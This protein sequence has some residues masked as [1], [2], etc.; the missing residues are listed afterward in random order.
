MVGDGFVAFIDHLFQL[1]KKYEKNL[2]DINV[3]SIVGE[4]LQNNIFALYRKTLPE[5]GAE[6]VVMITKRHE[7]SVKMQCYDLLGLNRVLRTGR[8]VNMANVKM[9]S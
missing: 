2:F 1:I 4:N 7:D 5:L 6:L 8:L 9:A 3:N